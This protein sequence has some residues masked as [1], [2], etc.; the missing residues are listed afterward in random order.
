ML[1]DSLNQ[2]MNSAD[3]GI[4][5]PCVPAGNLLVLILQAQLT[6]TNHRGG[7]HFPQGL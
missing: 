3:S 6:K 1:L 7:R 2:M 5:H 4:L